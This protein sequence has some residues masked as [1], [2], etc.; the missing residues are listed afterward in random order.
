M[1]E[2]LRTK[3]KLF[4]DP[5][6]DLPTQVQVLR[7]GDFNYGGEDLN[8]TPDMLSKMKQ[9]FDMN[10][11][12]VDLAIDYSHN[13]FGEAAGW[14]KSLTLSTDGTQLWA[15]VDWT[16]AGMDKVKS[17]EFR[18]LS[19]DFMLDY[20]DNEVGASHGCTL[21]GAGLTNRPFVKDMQPIM[22][23]DEGK[24]GKKGSEK[25]ALQVQKVKPDSK[26][27]IKMDEKEKE[28]EALKATVEAMKAEKSSVDAELSDLRKKLD[29][30]SKEKLLA[31]KTAK[32]EKLLG[33]GKLCPAQKEAFIEGD[34]VKLAELA[35]PVKTEVVGH[36]KDGVEESA[37][38]D[39][40]SQAAAQ[41]IIKL[42]EKMHSEGKSISFREAILRVRR[43]NPELVNRA[44]AN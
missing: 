42:A 21:M 36:G 14:I 3:P 22:Q 28:L 31:E 39:M 30:V 7:C 35:A 24:S 1:S 26:G 16:P 2:I 43:E 32:F 10:T 17:K 27:G 38:A 20:V 34:A 11:R 12:G 5:S 37:A 29:E 6:A 4:A 9:N 8:I 44:S 41:E 19:A 15:S 13:A 40:D 33:E 23:L 25:T 18:Y